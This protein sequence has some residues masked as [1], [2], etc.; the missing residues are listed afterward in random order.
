VIALDPNAWQ[1]AH[2]AGEFWRI[3]PA[4]PAAM[5]ILSDILDLS[6]GAQIQAINAFLAEHLHVDDLQRMVDRMTDPDDTFGSDGGY[7]DLYRAAVTAGTARPFWQSS[8]LPRQPHTA[9]GLSEPS[10]LSAVWGHHSHN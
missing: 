1:V 6:G 10:W 9:G 5:A 2:V 3:K 4:T 7:Q 8:A